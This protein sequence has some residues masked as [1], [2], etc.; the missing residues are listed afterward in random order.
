MKFFLLWEITSPL[1]TCSIRLQFPKNIISCLNNICINIISSSTNNKRMNS[2]NSK[3]F[4]TWSYMSTEKVIS[5]P[6][7]TTLRCLLEM[8]RLVRISVLFIPSME[9]INS[10]KQVRCLTTRTSNW[11]PFPENTKKSVWAKQESYT[12]QKELG[13]PNSIQTSQKHSKMDKVSIW[14]DK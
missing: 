9:S 1:K 14:K 13:S 5:M 12:H 8:C 11:C 10:S 7:S 4:S 2:S 3:K 6:R